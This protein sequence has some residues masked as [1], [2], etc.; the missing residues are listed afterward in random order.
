[1]ARK[2]KANIDELSELEGT[3]NQIVGKPKAN[4]KRRPILLIVLLSILLVA[5]LVAGA[6]ILFSDHWLTL[7]DV[8]VAGIPMNGLTKHEA[9]IQ[10][11]DKAESVYRSEAMQVTV[12]DTVI[13]ITPEE[14][15]IQIDADKAIDAAYGCTGEFDLSPYISFTGTGLNQAISLLGEKYNADLKPTEEQVEGTMPSLENDDAQT[16]Q[17]L[18]LTLGTPEM[19][20]D[21]AELRAAILAGYSKSVF[22]VTGDCKLIPPEIPTADGLYEKY[23]TA[24]V[25]AEMDMTTFV[26]SQESYGYS[27][28]P[29]QAAQL[30]ANATYG[31]TLRIPFVKIAPKVTKSELEATLFQDILGECSTP[32][33]GW[34]NDNRN[35]NLRLACEK[36]D[37][38]VLLPGESFSY[39]Q[40]LGE[41]TGENGWKL[42]GSYVGGETVSTYGGGTCQGSTTLY[43]CVLLG[44]LKILEA[45]PHGYIS[46]YVDPGLDAMVNWGTS[47][48]R[49]VNSTNW[50]IRIEAYRREGKM[51]MRI[52]GTDEKDYYIKMTYKVMSS[53]PYETVYKDIDPENNPKG[54]KDGQVITDPYTGYHVISYKNKYSKATD[55]LLET[56]LE[57]D[58]RYNKR[59][60]VIA[61][62]PAKEEAP[63][64]TQPEE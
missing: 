5:I 52:Y 63:E 35:T 42:A 62:F 56:T 16:G 11:K 15:G 59:D 13:T 49:F 46:S 50:P 4:K 64:E 55:E 22:A 54:Y 58:S 30:L 44:D 39:N 9:K 25:D 47:D 8:T 53:T 29:Q 14:A 6:W 3:Y 51:T 31:D 2:K 61:R 32:Y 48:L 7:E 21:T 45:N 33:S 37:G 60:K 18:V 23:L 36:I 26:V 57:R 43:N 1:M 40:T 28:D 38:I 10:L 27:V 19:G 20:L 34:D 41:R 12:L 17:T 24:P